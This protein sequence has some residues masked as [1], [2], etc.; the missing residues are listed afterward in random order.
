[1]WL[2]KRGRVD[3]INYLWCGFVYGTP[4]ALSAAL[5]TTVFINASPY[6]SFWLILASCLIVAWLVKSVTK[7]RY[8]LLMATS[9]TL[10]ATIIGY[11]FIYGKYTLIPA[12]ITI[13]LCLLM[14]VI[15]MVLHSRQLKIRENATVS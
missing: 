10:I 5:M 1:M 9:A 3:N 8:F 15:L 11:S 12:I 2:N 7:I 6:W 14:Y 13:N 4:L